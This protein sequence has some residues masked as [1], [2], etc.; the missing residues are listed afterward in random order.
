MALSVVDS[1]RL[2]AGGLRERKMRTALT[3]LGNVIG[4][5][6]IVALQASTQGQS[7]AIS[8]S[9]EKLGPT[10]LIV[11]TNGFR[12]GATQFTQTT[13]QNVQ[14][15][16]HVQTAFLAVT[17]DGT[18]T[19][20]GESDGVSIQGIA[21][22]DLTRL[23]RGLQVQ[24][25]TLYSDGDL[26]SAFLGNTAATPTD[27]TK[28][29]SA[30]GD[31]VQ[32]SVSVRQA[33]ASG[34]GSS[35]TVTR[36][37]V[38]TGVAAAFG[39][40][41]FLSVD[42]SVFMTPRAAQ[43]MLNLAT[44]NYNEM[45]VMADSSENV[46]TVQSE[47][48]ALLGNNTA[49]VQSSTQLASTITSVYGTVTSLL[50]S[51]A[52]ISLIVAGVGIAN[53]MF[54]S[55]IERT[56]EIG[57]LKALGFKA[58]EVLGVFLLEASLTGVIGGILGCLAGVA[59]AFG[60]GQF[61]SFSPT[62]GGGGGAAAARATTTTA[63]GGAA[64]AGVQGGGFGG[65]GPPGGFGGGPGGGGGFNNA[66][67][68]AAAHATPVFTVEMFAIVIVFA[69]VVAVVAGLIPARKAAKMDPVVA[70]KRL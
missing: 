38:V 36:Q 13:L 59:V 35:V 9:L 6:M 53:T 61:I 65:G 44:V 1:L 40:A 32:V 43:Q 46:A 66:A 50:E 41:P 33:T 45:I 63:A 24:E 69:I 2:A 21:P 19:R 42:G 57:T 15:L 37:Y 17:G 5:S 67:S 31:S 34:P 14:A 12:S 30:T 10:T 20:G 28:L 49:R 27:T 39:S 48:Q 11:Q 68:S 26:T 22:E 51:V 52:A 23:V 60:I 25:G 58:R 56:T 7:K 18:I 62:G 8:D 54:V 47:I 4:T 29:P 55:V 3:L 70:L 64:R 16:D